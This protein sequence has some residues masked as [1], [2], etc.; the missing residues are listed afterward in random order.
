MKINIVLTLIIII[1]SA[2]LGY[3]VYSVAEADTHATLAGVLSAICL[4]IPLI[5]GFGVS[6]KTSAALV[7]VRTLSCVLFLL[8]LILHF[9]YAATGIS[10]PYYILINGI[11]ICIYVAIVYTILKSKQ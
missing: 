11:L 6:Y 3:W 7:N 5:F 1:L 10:M 4:A 2:L 8:M 9:Y